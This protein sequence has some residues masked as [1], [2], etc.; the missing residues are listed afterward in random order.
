MRYEDN[1]RGRLKRS[2][3]RCYYLKGMI[4]RGEIEIN[5]GD[6]VVIVGETKAGDKYA[7]QFMRDIF[8]DDEH[9]FN[10]GCHGKGM[11][12]RC[13]YVPKHMVKL[14]TMSRRKELLF[15]IL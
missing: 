8:T 15:A 14:K 4:S 2:A 12:N 9:E 7:V 5:A 11:L 10:S 6:N 3:L 13:L 1:K